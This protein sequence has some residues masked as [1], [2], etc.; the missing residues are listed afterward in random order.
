[1]ILLLACANSEGPDQTPAVASD[2]ADSSPTWSVGDAI[3]L[4]GTEPAGR[5]AEFSDAALLDDGRG[6]VVGVEGFGLV[7][8]SGELLLQSDAEALA[9]P[10][11]KSVAIDGD[12]AWVSSHDAG[13]YQLDLSGDE[14]VHLGSVYAEAH[15]DIAAEGGVVALA[16]LDGVQLLDSAGAVL[17]EFAGSGHAVAI[18]EDEVLASDGSDLVRFD[19]EGNELGRMSLDGAARDIDWAGNIAAV[20]LG[21]RGTAVVDTDSM[22]L[23]HHVEHPGTSFS[24]S[25]DDDALWIGAWNVSV[26]VDLETGAVLAHESPQMS[27]MAIAAADGRA[28]VADWNHVAALERTPGVRGPELHLPPNLWTNGGVGTPIE[29]RGWSAELLETQWEVLS[30]DLVLAASELTVAPGETARIELS[31]EGNGTLAYT[32]NDP[33][34]ASGELPVY[35]TNVLNAPHADFEL[36]GLPDPD[37]ELRPYRLSEQLGSPVLMLFWESTCPICAYE[38]P[39]VASTY[40]EPYPELVVWLVNAGEEEEEVRR[41]LGDAGVSLPCLLDSDFDITRA[42]G[43]IPGRFAGWPQQV[44]VDRNGDIAFVQ[45]TY[46]AAAMSSAIEEALAR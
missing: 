10:P 9:L 23:L 42:Y 16:T 17:A 41:F 4:V 2:S 3:T 22:V 6:L 35:A 46:D 19:L 11:A 21:G 36:L 25:L 18:E 28:I 5:L 39:D 14:P 8:P 32:S 7:S 31:G 33:D 27:A 1:M 40:A 15:R 38:I 34:E 13:L 26:L 12:L 30:G 29:L 37:A 44:L 45:A 20:A 43:L 24:V